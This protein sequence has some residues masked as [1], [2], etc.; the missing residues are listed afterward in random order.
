MKTGIISICKDINDPR[1][2][3]KKIHKMESIV[4]IAMVAV[5][6]G[7]QSWNEIEEFGN[8]KLS[9]FK[10]HIPGL[11]TIPSHD[12]FN[13]FFSILDPDQFEQVFRNWVKQICREVKGVVS[14]DGKLMRG[15]SRCDEDHPLGN[16]D[17]RLWIVSAWSKANGISLGQEKVGEKSNEITAI[18]KLL[19]ALDISD[20]IITI[21]AMGCQSKITQEIIER[22]G[23]YVIALKKNQRTSYKKA[24]KMLENS[25]LN[26]KDLKHISHFVSQSKG[27]GRLETRT[28]TVLGGYQKL[29]ADIFKNRFEGLNSVIEVIRER[30]NIKTGV[31]TRQTRY[32]ISSLNYKDPER[33]ADIIREHWSIENNLHWQLDVSFREDL[34]KKTK[35]AARNFSAVTKIALSVLKNDKTTKG[36]INLKR[37]KAGWSND[38][39]EKLLQE[40]AF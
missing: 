18:P 34:S 10:A 4:Y 28:V 20:C 14:I 40:N 24:A 21:D 6:C 1:M 13:R 38:Y 8:A 37:L 15:P 19:A 7:A 29:M 11:E 9:F 31:T 35:N 12:T 36:S 30:K 27:H 2:D 32:Y 39:L 33:I 3:R 5:I 17:F 16:K 22:K 23:D 25:R 26:N